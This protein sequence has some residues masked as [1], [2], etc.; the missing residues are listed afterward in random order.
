M[1]NGYFLT[2]DELVK[3]VYGGILLFCCRAC[4]VSTFNSE[5]TAAS[6]MVVYGKFNA[7]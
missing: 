1:M 4:R 6:R 5:A 2:W 3:N 7:H